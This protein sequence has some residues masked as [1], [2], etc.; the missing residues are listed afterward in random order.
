MQRKRSQC[1]AVRT[2]PFRL[3]TAICAGGLLLGGCKDE[4]P[5][6]AAAGGEGA[7]F[8]QVVIDAAKKAGLTP[9]PFEAAAARPYK[10]QACKR[11]G[12]AKLDVL[13]CRYDDA[14]AAASHEKSFE[15]FLSGAVTGVVRKKGATVVAIADRD[16]TDLRGKTIN[17]LVA[18]VTGK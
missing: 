16:K 10:A 6:V 12:I 9:E 15:Q 3:L 1:S 7:D 11:G 13:V 8:H 2:R 18:A 5:G 4:K 17:K 14:K